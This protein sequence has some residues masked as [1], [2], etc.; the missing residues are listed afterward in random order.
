MIKKI[1]NWNDKNN[2]V[3]LFFIA[4]IILIALI[5]FIILI[6][7]Y[8]KQTAIEKDAA[9]VR[10][11]ECRSVT[12]INKL[13]EQLIK[14]ISIETLSGIPVSHKDFENAGTIIFRNFD[15]RNAF[16]DE[17][18][19]KLIL[20]DR[21]GLKYEKA[22]TANTKGNTDVTIEKSDYVKQPGDFTR[23]IEKTLN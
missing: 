14:K 15:E 16:K 11:S 8:N 23:K 22:F 17:S 1:K 13:D 9:K 10:L 12:V 7:R 19:F 4:F 20:I 6:N 5:T 2:K 3:L 18:D 21:Y